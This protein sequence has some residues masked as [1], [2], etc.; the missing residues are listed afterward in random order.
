M[1]KAKIDDIRYLFSQ[2]LDW[3]RRKEL[4]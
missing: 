2:D 3:V 1:M 4:I